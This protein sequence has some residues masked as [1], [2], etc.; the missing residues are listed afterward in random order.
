MGDSM[1]GGRAERRRHV[2]RAGDL[3]W[4]RA[5]RLQPGLEAVLAD[6]SPGGAL[7]ETATRLRLG[8]KTV[9]LLKTRDGE[10]R[11]PA[12]VLRAWVSSL[13]P[14]RGILYRG[15]LRFDRP[16]DLSERA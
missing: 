16:I 14:D 13:L 6:L 4:L 8:M 1:T 5:A 2:R 12:G 7:V 10:L 9:L 11:A 3:P 15:A